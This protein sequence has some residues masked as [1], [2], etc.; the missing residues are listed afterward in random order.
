MKLKPLDRIKYNYDG[1]IEKG[2][3]LHIIEAGVLVQ[4]D[5]APVPKGPFFVFG[6]EIICKMKKGKR[7]VIW[8]NKSDLDED[9]TLRWCEDS[10]TSVITDIC[11]G[12]IDKDWEKPDSIYDMLSFSTTIFLSGTRLFIDPPA[13]PKIKG[14]SKSLVKNAFTFER[15][16]G[17]LFSI[18]FIMAIGGTTIR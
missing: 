9:G 14:R 4:R 5:N 18:L 13:I 2:T 7:R 17:A 6:C 10:M 11:T 1:E 16:L 8:L 15:I 12:E 3:V